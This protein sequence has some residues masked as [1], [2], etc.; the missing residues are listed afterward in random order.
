[1][2]DK[3]CCTEARMKM[4]A[5]IESLRAKVE[6]LSKDCEAMTKL[7]NAN[8]IRAEVQRAKV[9]ELE[10]KYSRLHTAVAEWKKAHVCYVHDD[11]EYAQRLDAVLRGEG[12]G[13]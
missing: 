11:C 5:T 10:K 7:S 9:E 1:M 2:N 12:G 6:E 4:S 8:A 13:R 3:M